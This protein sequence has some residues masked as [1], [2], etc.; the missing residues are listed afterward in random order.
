[1]KINQDP[2]YKTRRRVAAAS[3]ISAVALTGVVAHKVIDRHD[4]NDQLDRS[5]QNVATAYADG[6]IDQSKVEWVTAKKT[7]PVSRIA[8]DIARDNP[9]AISE[10]N[11]AMIAQHGATALEGDA[12]LL[13]KGDIAQSPT[14]INPAKPGNQAAFIVGRVAE[15]HN[16]E[17]VQGK[18]SGLPG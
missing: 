14:D 11:E 10:V 12:Y 6:K 2:I 17:I 18:N 7:A 15:F 16:S 13:S 5:A 1:M 3:L 4:L 8:G 9:D